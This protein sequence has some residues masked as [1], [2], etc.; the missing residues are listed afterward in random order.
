MPKLH[1]SR[2]TN[3]KIV[4]GQNIVLTVRNI[5]GDKVHLTFEAP[6]E[7][8]IDRFEIWLQKNQKATPPLKKILCN[9][10]EKKGHVCNP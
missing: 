9:V 7:V 8:P 10:K 4:I 1:L 3:E 2:Y 6:K 5:D